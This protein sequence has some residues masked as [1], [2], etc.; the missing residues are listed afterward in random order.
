MHK[1]LLFS[2]LVLILFNGLW[3]STQILSLV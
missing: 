3:C 1:E 2:I